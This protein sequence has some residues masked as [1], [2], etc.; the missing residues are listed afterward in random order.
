VC[1]CIYIYMCVYI[2]IAS[3]IY[4][5]CIKGSPV[6]ST[7]LPSPAEKGSMR[8]SFDLRMLYVNL[9]EECVAVWVD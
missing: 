1:V 5:T 3:V 9:K 6:E 2:Y 8:E 7:I 4:A